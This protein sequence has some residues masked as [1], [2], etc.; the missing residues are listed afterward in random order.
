MEILVYSIVFIVS[1]IVLIKSS[2]YFTEAAEKVGLFFKIPPF[3]IGV[4]IVS[5]GTSLPELAS[6][7]VAVFRD[8]SEIVVSNAV[9]SNVANV[10]LVL[11]VAA[12]IGKKLE[13]THEL[14]HVDLPLLMG[15]AFLLAGIAYDG[16]ITLFEAI[17]C[18]L[19]F[20]VYVTYTLSVQKE[21]KSKETTTKSIKVQK[22]NWHTPVILIVSA[23]FIYF[24][25]EQLIDSISKLST[26]LNI[27]KDV[28]TVTALAIG[29]SLPELVVSITAARKGKSEMAIGNVLGSNIFNALMV[30]GIPALFGTLTVTTD[31]VIFGLPAM[32]ATTIMCFFVMQDRQVTRYEGG[33]LVILYAFFIA[34]VVGFL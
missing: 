33:I 18:L 24:S 20:V 29:T 26:T 31:I 1:L 8:S 15:S 3:I 16:Q 34:K 13:V 22:L 7:L 9:G 12:L 11:G 21:H 5:V 14:V 10:L 25:A 28:I 6:G 4:T 17:L 2:D 27:G 23:V 19:G 32:V 30:T